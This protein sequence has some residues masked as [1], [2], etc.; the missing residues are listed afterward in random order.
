MKKTGIL[1]GLMTAGMLLLTGC[2]GNADT[3]PS[4]S[5]SAT[6]M[7]TGTPRPAATGSPMESAAPGAAGMQEGMAAA[8]VNSVEDARRVSGQ[9]A[10]EV[11]KLSELDDAEAV[12][13]GTIALVGIEY[14]DQYQGGLTDRLKKMIQERVEKIDKAVTTVHVTDNV[15]WVRK[16]KALEEKLDETGFG[17]EMLQTG[18]L[19]IGS[20]IAGGS[21][22]EVAKPQMGN[23]QPPHQ[24]QPTAGV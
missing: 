13:A 5:P 20:A 16:I 7:P 14:D 21:T 2:T 1:L 24:P 22:P 8:G 9:I 18:I 10:E 11:E 3:L 23:T 17:F 6:G 15:E 19:E 4:P 12:V